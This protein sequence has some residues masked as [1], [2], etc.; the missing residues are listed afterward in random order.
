MFQT[1]HALVLDR[2]FPAGK[3]RSRSFEGVVYLMANG[4]DLERPVDM[5]VLREGM[6]NFRIGPNLFVVIEEKW[7]KL[8]QAGTDLGYSMIMGNRA[9][10]E[11][12]KVGYT[13]DQKYVGK[14]FDIRLNPHCGG[15]GSDDIEYG[16]S[17]GP[18]SLRPITELEEMLSRDASA[19]LLPEESINNKDY[20]V[21]MRHDGNEVLSGK[22][23]IIKEEPLIRV[24]DG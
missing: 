1:K 9:F 17:M 13:P 21:L 4:F 5:R 14:V 8:A 3:S 7:A 16:M 10:I 2:D 15:G 20:I 12:V 22:N 11:P 18:H 23:V 24:L 6:E 19:W